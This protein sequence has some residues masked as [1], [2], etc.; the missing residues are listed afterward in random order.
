MMR[1]LCLM[2]ALLAIALSASAPN[3]AGSSR[4]DIARAALSQQA[5]P[6][7]FDG[8]VAV[9]RGV[10]QLDV[11]V[12]GG[13]FALMPRHRNGQAWGPWVSLGGKL[14]SEPAAVVTA[15]G[16][17]IDVVARG[18]D[19]TMWLNTWTA[20]RGGWSGWRDT[21][22]GRITSSPSLTS[23][24]AGTLDAFALTA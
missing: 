13:D 22:G 4:P 5:T 16:R 12:R 19:A 6:G 23:R 3:A 1:A 11:F 17:R 14:D 20:E 24:T 10:G 15:G 2:P 9:T 18:T 8:V 7:S 21:G